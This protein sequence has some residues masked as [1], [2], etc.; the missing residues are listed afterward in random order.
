VTLVIGA[1][2][3][4]ATRRLVDL[5]AFSVVWSMGSLLIALGLFDVAGLTAALYYAV[6]S[7]VA[8]A[9]LFLI[10]DMVTRRRGASGDNLRTAPPIANDA[11]VSGLFFVAAIAMAGLPPFSGFIGKLLILDAT[12][13][14]AYGP[15]IWG[16]ILATSLVV[17]IGFARAGSTVF[18]KAQAVGGGLVAAAPAP[19]R[20]VDTPG[21]ETTTMRLA[22]Y[23]LL[24]VAA[25]LVLLAGPVT[26]AFEATARQ[27]LDPAGYVAAVFD[28]AMIPEWS[29]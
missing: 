8:A 10:A 6:H 19:E 21:A 13:A 20:E 12:R 4:L 7:T 17:V 27:I 14:S 18:W 5:V 24:A 23:A 11:L 15:W 3:V 25:L 22:V 9:V 1:L 29:R 16:L 2:G 28:E 26:D